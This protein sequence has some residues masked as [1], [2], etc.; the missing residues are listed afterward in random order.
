MEIS[1]GNFFK[2]LQ[3]FNIVSE[4]GSISDAAKKLKVSQPAVSYL[5]RSLE[6]ELGVELFSR[7]GSVLKLSEAGALLYERSG[8]LMEHFYAVKMEM[9]SLGKNGYRGDIVMATTH[10]F[11]GS[12]LP[13]Y[14]DMFRKSNPEVNFFLITGLSSQAII[15][16]VVKAEADFG[17]TSLDYIPNNIRVDFLFQTRLVLIAP[18][19]W[20]FSRNEHGYIG[21]LS[22]LEGMPF[23]MYSPGGNVKRYIDRYIQ[24]KDI[25]PRTCIFINNNN[26]IRAFVR[27]GVGCA[28]VEDFERDN[29]GWYNIY[30]LPYD[31]AASNYYIL[32][33]R[34]KYMS[35]QASAFIRNIL[36][37]KGVDGR[38]MDE[39]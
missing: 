9:A 3:V 10:S 25:C 1:K 26:D 34:R 13:S 17:I 39:P 32:R 2:W 27:A 30:R 31:N 33:S 18:H 38:P 16:T 5:L 37:K 4:T 15:D 24:S 28:I 7:R 11:A 20:T 29:K 19:E 12:H 35:P 8:L 36:L 21:D 22:E 14:V 6:T 23:L